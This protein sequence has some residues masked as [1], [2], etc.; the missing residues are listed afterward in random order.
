M[1]SLRDRALVEARARASTRSRRS[2][3]SWR[4]MLRFDIIGSAFAISVFLLF[5]YIAVGFFVVYFA[6]VYGY[7]PSAGQRAWPT[8]T[9]SATRSPCRRRR[10]LRLAAGAQAVHDRRRGDQR[11]RHRRCSRS[12]RTKP[13]P[14]Y[15]TFALVFIL[16]SAGGGMAYAAWMASFTETVEKHN[17]AAT[18]T[19]LAVWG[20]ILR[21]VVTVSLAILT[22]VAAG[23]LRLVDQGPA[24]QAILAKYPQEIATAQPSTRLRR[25]R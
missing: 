19:G 14:D 2:R 16:A 7:T 6:T 17:P 20:W 10:A 1:V 24:T 5:Y 8:G 12:P 3:A 13:R 9:G 11:C 22:L 23:D 15:Y 18:A 21:I 25:P 4:Q